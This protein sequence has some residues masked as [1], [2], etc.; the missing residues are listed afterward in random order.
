MKFLVLH[1]NKDA[2]LMLPLEQKMTIME[3]AVAFIEKYRNVSKCK[4]AYMDADLQGGASI[5][6]VDSEEEAAKLILENPMAPFLNAELRP[7]I[8]WY[9]AVKAQQEHLQNLAK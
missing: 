4:E 2:F 3:G 7:V 6:D 8:S 9:T 5:W 1:R